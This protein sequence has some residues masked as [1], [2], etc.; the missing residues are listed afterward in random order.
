M[1]SS[2]GKIRL[3]FELVVSVS[4]KGFLKENIDSILELG[5]LLYPSSRSLRAICI[6]QLGIISILT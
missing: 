1:C 5:R 4:Q 2:R 3:I 6:I